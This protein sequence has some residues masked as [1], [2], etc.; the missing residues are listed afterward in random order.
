MF[1]YFG[2]YQAVNA[3]MAEMMGSFQRGHFFEPR[4]FVLVDGQPALHLLHYPFSSLFARVGQIAV[5][6]SSH[7]IP[8]IGKLQAVAFYNLSLVMFYRVSRLFYSSKSSVFTVVMMGL[9]PMFLIEATAFRNESFALLTSISA[10]YF[11]AKPRPNIY[12]SAI[13]FSIS[14]MSRL[15]FAAII[16]IILYVMTQNKKQFL[17]DCIRFFAVTTIILGFWIAYFY[18][19][20]LSNADFVQTS[21]FAQAEEGRVFIF[22]EIFSFNFLKRLFFQF[23]VYLFNPIFWIGILL[24]ISKLFKHENKV[25]FI[26]LFSALLVVFILPKKVFD[27]PFYLLPAVPA[28]CLL[29]ARWF[30]R[31]IKS[32]RLAAVIFLLGFICSLGVCWKPLFYVPANTKDWLAVADYVNKNI[33]IK[34]KII[35]A[36][37]QSASMLYYSHRNGWGFDLNMKAGDLSQSKQE[38]YVQLVKQGYGDPLTWLSF[39]K[40][41]GA[42]HFIATDLEA[43][44]SGNIEASLLL[45]GFKPFHKGTDFIG[46]EIE[47]YK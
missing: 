29:S 25:F 36:H 24:G 19:L 10:F 13:F 2:S 16:L 27:H 17:N 28:L 1:G 9:S 41:T 35:M 23:G 32:D 8:L 43:V 33:P 6:V 20:Q 42:T 38:R 15:H 22:N 30:E 11:A 7:W 34:A 37:E 21:L 3:M 4:T 5:N 45:A 39:L 40:R 12:V 31:Q 14:V 18:Y 26:W 47:N 46:Y 44:S